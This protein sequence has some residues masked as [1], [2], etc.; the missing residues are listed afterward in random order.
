M[1]VEPGTSRVGLVPR[2]SLHPERMDR[3]N[4]AP[5]E[6]GAALRD[7][8]LTNRW[9]GGRRVLL[10]ALRPFVLSGA[11]PLDV[12]DVGTGS[13]DLPLAMLRFG[14][15]HGR[16]LRITAI[17]IDPQTAVLAAIAAA[18]SS[19]VRVVRTDARRPPF[20]DRSFDLVTVSMFLHHF[21]QQDVVRLLRR[22]R[23]LAREAVIVNDLRRHL[24]PWAFI[25]LAS[26]LTLRSRMY[27][28]D[29]P[30]SVLR[31]FTPGELL[32]AA[33][34]AGAPAVPPRRRWPYRLVT[35][36]PAADTA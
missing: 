12:L 35:T 7:I 4:Q 20:A 36:L 32:D 25:L 15:K 23:R 1:P 10:D 22:F 24:V 33:R 17:D 31:G 13:A 18:D 21:G 11:G 14:R 30:L 5:A 8:R 27:A 26:R 6:L 29:A 3:P 34:R 16:E 9:L 19:A 28:H 2:R